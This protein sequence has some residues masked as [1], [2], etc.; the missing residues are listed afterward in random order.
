MKYRIQAEQ[1]CLLENYN[2]DDMV[3]SDPVALKGTY[4]SLVTYECIIEGTH[5][6]EYSGYQTFYLWPMLR[7]NITH[8]TKI[9]RIG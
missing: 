2:K 3:I 8:S 5:F 4:W 1:S 6:F 7:M 9:S